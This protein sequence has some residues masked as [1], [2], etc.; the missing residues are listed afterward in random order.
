MQVLIHNSLFFHQRYGG[1]SRYSS[2]LTKSLME[3][4]IDLSIIAP[5]YKNIYINDI[6]KSKIHG[7]YI[8][9]YPNL[10]FLRKINNR[11]VEFY[12]DNLNADIVHDSYYPESYNKSSKKKNYDNS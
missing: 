9:R 8:S 11:L 4:K 1:V 7:L 6:K 10:K 3:N 2:C 12:K 5:I